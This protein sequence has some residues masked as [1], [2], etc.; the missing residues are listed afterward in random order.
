MRPNYHCLSQQ[1]QFLR[2]K[3]QIL[4]LKLFNIKYMINLKNLKS[5]FV[6]EEEKNQD[7]QPQNE[8]PQKEKNDETVPPPLPVNNNNQTPP[9][10]PP[11]TSGTIDKRVYEKLLQALEASNMEGYDY[12]EF[13]ASLQAMAN[14]PLDE[15]TR[16]RS[17]FAA[18][19]AMGLT[20]D[21]LTQSA[22]YYKGILEKEN[23]QFKTE[24]D[25]Q[26][27][28][29]IKTK[30]AEKTRMEQALE[31]KKEQIRLLNEQINQG[32][33]MLQQLRQELAAMN[34]KIRETTLN[35]H[36]TYEYLQKQI[37]ADVEKI[38]MYLR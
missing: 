10:P 36:A 4:C 11:P 27:S 32:Q 21:K 29:R 17:A 9:P 1:T 13:R 26:V 35:F 37:D 31:E 19:T 20:T 6:V 28:D 12:I 22:A 15:A 33:A 3:K 24:L 7:E 2:I 34:N 5:I 16:F 23:N 8:Q 25:R 14:L 30:D 38:K 18:A